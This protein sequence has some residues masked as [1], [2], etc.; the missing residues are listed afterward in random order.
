MNKQQYIKIPETLWNDSRFTAKEVMIICYRLG[1]AD[2]YFAS[3]KVVA[4][5][6]GVDVSTVRRAFIK[7][8]KAGLLPNEACDTA[9]EACVYAREACDTARPSV[10]IGT[11]SVRIRTH[12]NPDLPMKTDLLYNSILD[13]D[14]IIDKDSSIQKP[15]PTSNI[16][17]DYKKS[18]SES[19]DI[20][21]EFNKLF[22]N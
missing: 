2:D 15:E 4:D 3:T 11:G 1:F 7:A 14:K 12:N 9:R 20:M 5:K 16:S 21:D 13:N 8:K 19:S 22:S 6:F 10:P 18:P 17:K